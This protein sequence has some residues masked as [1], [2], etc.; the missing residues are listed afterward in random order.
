M[1]CRVSVVVSTKDR[2]DHVV[3]CVRC[4]LANRNADFDL[5]VV[6]QSETAVMDRARTAVGDDPRLRWITTGTRGLSA[7]RNIGVSATAAPVIAFTDDDCRVPSDWIARLQAAFDGHED[8]A[9]VFGAVVL[10]P[11]DRAKGYAAEFGPTATTEYQHVLPD[12]ESQWGVGANMAIRR[13]VLERIGVF[14]LMLGAGAPFCSAEEID[15]TIRALAAGFK[16]IHTP[17][18]SVVHL[19]VREGHAAS[20][21]MRGY[22]IGLGATFAKHVRLRTPGAPRMLRQWLAIH[23]RRSLRNAMR[24]HRHPGFGLVAA[25]LLGISRSFGKQVDTVSRTYRPT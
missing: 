9:I 10:P 6:D 7:S 16:V 2:P 14:D 21:L 20:L 4:V 11:D 5:V 23:G 13:T 12:L 17:E 22:G 18:V 15:L 3:D 25:V 1:S 24:G 8:R 19:G